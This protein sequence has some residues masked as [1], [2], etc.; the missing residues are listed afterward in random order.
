MIID[1]ENSG[2][3]NTGP[4]EGAE[5]VSNGT[6]NETVENANTNV[7]ESGA[8]SDTNGTG[9][10]GEVGETGEESTETVGQETGKDDPVLA[11]KAQIEELT[12]KLEQQINHKEPP[13]VKE[14]SEAEWAAKE[15]EWG[16]PRTA[17]QAVTSQNVYLYNKIKQDIMAEFDKRMGGFEKSSA[18]QSLAKDPK[19][20]D[21]PKYAKDVDEFIK[22]YPAQHHSNPELLKRAVIYARGL[23]IGKTVSKVRNEGERNRTITGAGK[24]NSPNGGIRNKVVPLTP[25]QKKYADSM[26][27]EAEYRKYMNGKSNGAVLIEK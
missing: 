25:I 15:T 3:E 2:K 1:G 4:G 27:G 11:I 19:F 5:G 14:L 24:P 20:S 10:G 6:E 8:E 18:L 26:G 12:K 17:I 16:V 13:P 22:D 21:A 23:N 7:N 9:T